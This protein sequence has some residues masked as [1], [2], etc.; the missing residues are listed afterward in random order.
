MKIL[1]KG[2]SYEVENIERKE[3][4]GQTIEFASEFFDGTTEE[5]IVKVLIHRFKF[6]KKDTTALESILIDLI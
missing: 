5:E 2:I 1:V 3:K 4:K 6:L